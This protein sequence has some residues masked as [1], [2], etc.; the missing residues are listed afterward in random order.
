MQEVKPVE[1]VEY[2]DTVESAAVS[3]VWKQ[4]KTIQKKV[5]R[6]DVTDDPIKTTQLPILYAVSMYVQ[7]P[8]SVIKV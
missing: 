5:L 8:W 7:E 1:E 6:I 4:V 3:G 2:A